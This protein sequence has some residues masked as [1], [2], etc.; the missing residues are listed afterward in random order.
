MA[1]YSQ[2]A[3]PDPTFLPGV[4]EGREAHDRS[5]RFEQCE[6]QISPQ[7][8]R[9]P[10]RMPRSVRCW[11]HSPDL[12]APSL[13]FFNSAIS[14]CSA[15]IFFMRDH[16]PTHEADIIAD[17]QQWEKRGG[18]EVAHV[19]NDG[20]RAVPW[21][22]DHRATRSRLSGVPIRS[23]G[24]CRSQGVLGPGAGPSRQ[25]SCAGMRAQCAFRA[26]TSGAFRLRSLCFLPRAATFSRLPPFCN[27]GWAHPA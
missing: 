22:G 4:A 24:S 8:S 26:E 13:A 14:A 3:W 5:L 15:V 21:S 12:A 18:S 19:T 2:T 27:T 20:R 16:R 11:P 23:A 17:Y 7:S 25:L 6:S 9:R 10:Q 1:F